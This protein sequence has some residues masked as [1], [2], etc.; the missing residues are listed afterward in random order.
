M[1]RT[2]ACLIVKNE[3]A[4]IAE[5]AIHH[6]LIGFDTLIIYDHQSSDSTRAVLA[7]LSATM[8]ILL[9]DWADQS[10]ERQN[11]AY[12]DCL[13][14]HGAD[15]EWIGFLDTDEF[16]IGHPAQ[17]LPNLLRQH[18]NA[19]GIVLNWV[20]FGTAGHSTLKPGSIMGSLTRRS[21]YDFGVNRH[22]KS[23]V[24]PGA[25][26]R[27]LNPHA[28]DLDGDTVNTDGTKVAWD[29]PGLVSEGT[30]RHD[31]W[32]VHHYF[33]RSAA[34]WERRLVRDQL[35]ADARHAAE[36]AVYD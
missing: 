25:V 21:P 11:A 1:T 4:D 20:I 15:F 32:R 26:K 7:A 31:G 9:H 14:R 36:F 6:H 10:S 3:A 13:V 12:R 19:A 33:L 27:V 23:I 18:E 22:V 8:P 24:R 35:G 29:K 30:A 5:W 34:H 17:T 28:F 2:A 16:L